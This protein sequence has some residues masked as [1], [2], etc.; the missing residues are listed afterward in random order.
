MDPFLLVPAAAA[1]VAWT[2]FGQEVNESLSKDKEA[3]DIAKS[4]A[5]QDAALENPGALDKAQPLK[6]KAHVPGLFDDRVKHFTTTSDSTFLP[7]GNRSHIKETRYYPKGPRHEKEWP[8]GETITAY[9][10]APQLRRERDRHQR[11]HVADA[12]SFV[13]ATGAIPPSGATGVYHPGK[14]TPYE[15]IKSRPLVTEVWKKI[16]SG[17]YAYPDKKLSIEGKEVAKQPNS[18]MQDFSGM[19]SI[20]NTSEKKL[21]TQ[22]SFNVVINNQL[23]CAAHRPPLHIA[24]RDTDRLSDK[25]Y[26]VNIQ[27]DQYVTNPRQ[28]IGETISN[29]RRK[30]VFED[31]RPPEISAGNFQSMKPDTT[32]LSQE[33]KIK[34]QRNSEAFVINRAIPDTRTTRPNRE[35]S[36]KDTAN[37]RRDYSYEWTRKGV[38]ETVS[39]ASRSYQTQFEPERIRLHQ[40]PVYHQIPT[41]GASWYD[42]QL[43]ARPL[44]IDRRDPLRHTD[45]SSAD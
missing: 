34:K 38:K 21:G 36:S 27:T 7:S 12:K 30:Q 44:A 8:F 43:I 45:A 25:A 15:A 17:A 20:E 26:N 11:L 41:F 42:R 39:S 29:H 23:N 40:D 2:T 3:T 4:I 24:R 22:K 18:Y 1:V 33:T 37:R 6:T 28:H 32:T 5:N 19:R 13:D 31:F 16:G 10:S 9:W 14:Q 35:V